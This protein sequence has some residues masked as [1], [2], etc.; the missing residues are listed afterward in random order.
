MV[1]K[2][3]SQHNL[4]Y[5]NIRLKKCPICGQS[6]KEL[7]RESRNSSSEDVLET[8][9]VEE[10]IAVENIPEQVH[11]MTIEVPEAMITPTAVFPKITYM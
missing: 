4:L 9:D 2:L 11:E 6:C 10:D 3:F 7:K 5:W 8:R 1:K